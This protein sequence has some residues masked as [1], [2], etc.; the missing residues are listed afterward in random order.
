M[1]LNLQRTKT[2]HLNLERTN[3]MHLNLERTTRRGHLQNVHVR[4]KQDLI[5]RT[6]TMYLDL[7]RT[8]TMHRRGELARRGG[9]AKPSQF[10]QLILNLSSTLLLYLSL[11]LSPYT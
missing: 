9:E 5:K 2:M 7:E 4:F 3:T 6:N 10:S 1:H 8:N 11:S